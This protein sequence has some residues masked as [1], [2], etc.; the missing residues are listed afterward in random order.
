[1][2]SL[3]SSSKKSPGNSAPNGPVAPP[4]ATPAVASTSARAPS[5]SLPHVARSAADTTWAT[6]SAVT[7]G[8]LRY[9]TAGRTAGPASSARSP[10]TDAWVC[11]SWRSIRPRCAAISRFLVSR[12]GA[13][14]TDLIESSGMPRSRSRLM[15][16][17]G[18]T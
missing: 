14:S 10:A 13:M 1:M 9:S 5:A 8:I 2:I 18:T 15:T 4:G 6:A 16:W 12:S 3:R 17:A 7:A 11:A